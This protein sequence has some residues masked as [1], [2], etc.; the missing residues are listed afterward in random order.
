MNQEIEIEYKNLLT[1]IEFNHLL[2]SLPFP[3]NSQ[4]Q[5]NY[6]FETENL[7][8]SKNKCA[9]RIREKDKVYTL[10]LKQPHP[11][12]VLETSDRLTKKEAFN[13]IQGNIIDKPNTI[14]QLAQLNI[15]PSSLM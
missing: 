2:Q 8:L 7:S 10:T 6:Y 5:V 1:A 13:W 11:Y 4:R 12:G 9:L 3:S 14:N 15:V